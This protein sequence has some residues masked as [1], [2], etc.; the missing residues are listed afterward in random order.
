[1]NIKVF[2]SWNYSNIKTS[3]ATLK[4]TSL[5]VKVVVTYSVLVVHDQISLAVL[6]KPHPVFI[7]D[8]NICNILL[9]THS[10]AGGDLILG[11][12]ECSKNCPEQPRPCV[13]QHRGEQQGDFLPSTAIP[14]HVG[15]WQLQEQ[16]YPSSIV[17]VTTPQPIHGTHRACKL[18]GGNKKIWIF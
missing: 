14:E 16:L 1:M 13:C 17:L 12:A 6:F 9:Y 10:G 8:I 5:P 18:D 15:L 7:S 4:I 11:R 2:K 3:F